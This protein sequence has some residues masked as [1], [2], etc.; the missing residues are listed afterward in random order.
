[1]LTITD[2]AADLLQHIRRRNSASNEATL[3]ID[4]QQDGQGVS[5]Q[6]V[7]GARPGDIVGDAHGLRVAVSPQVADQLDEAI[8]DAI[9]R[10]GA[11]LLVI[12]S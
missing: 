2:S 8:V 4:D 12:R 5:L 11:H 9:E 7:A 6:F 10:D 1:M 3:R